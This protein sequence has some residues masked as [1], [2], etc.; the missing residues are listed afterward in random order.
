MTE[1]TTFFWN[2]VFLDTALMD[3]KKPNNAEQQGPTRTSRAAAIVH[4]SLHDAVN[5]VQRRINPYLFTGTAPAG[6][7]PHAAAAGAAHA[8]LAALYPSQK[9]TLDQKLAQFVASLPTVPDPTIGIQFGVTVA[10]QL[11]ADRAND[12]AAS[13]SGYT[14]N[15]NP[16][17]GEW[18]PD[19]VLA[20]PGPPLT[21][22]WGNVRPFTL[23]R[24]D[25][26]RPPPPPGL[27]SGDYT[28]QYRIVYT[29][30]SQPSPPAQPPPLPPN[31]PPPRTN[32]ETEIAKFW[33][34][35]D[36]LGT[37]IRL[38]N[39]H[40]RQILEQELHPPQVSVLH[41]RA[42]IFALINI[43]MAD[44]GIGCW[45]AKFFYNYWRP[46]QGIREDDSNPNTP[47]NPNWLPLGRPRATTPQGNPVGNTTPNFPA[48]NSGHGCFGS[49]TFGML[50]KFFG[51][52]QFEFD[53]QSE[54][55]PGVVRMYNG[56]GQAIQENS[57]SR[58][59]MG[60]HWLRDQTYSSLGQ[61]VADHIWPNFLRPINSP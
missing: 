56:F 35:D 34:Y 59:F 13:Q 38:Y 6:S 7:S 40:A 50:R 55:L 23:P 41:R 9:S 21:P 14:P 44:A 26:L 10:Q 4:A 32:D 46:F 45:E 36:G 60:V 16:G 31:S 51:T 57:D 22:N 12:G 47:R 49:A 52:D 28:Y 43:A 61:Q 17:P 39:Q 58:I 29:K 25:I 42:R 30:G 8:A 18:R 24:G 37:P 15:P 11:L 2:Q 33:S 53:L 48:Y 5:G 54:E 3:S 19:P 1:E 20:P 27:S